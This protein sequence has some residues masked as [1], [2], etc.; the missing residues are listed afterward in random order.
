MKPELPPD[1][2]A[3]PPRRDLVL[4][5][6]G[7]ALDEVARDVAKRKI[8]IA[9]RLMQITDNLEH[10]GLGVEPPV[11][12]ELALVAVEDLA[13]VT[14]RPLVVND[15]EEW[16]EDLVQPRLDRGSTRDGSAT[17]WP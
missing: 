10:L 11:G 7:V 6:L 4:D 9:E 16:D 12:D 8:G 14:T 5:L 17:R 15:G 1:E 2:A 13:K 3:H